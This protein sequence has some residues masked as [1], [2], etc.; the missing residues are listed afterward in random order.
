[1][2]AEFNLLETRIA[3]IKCY[4]TALQKGV[5]ED[6]AINF[7]TNL[8]AMR[9]PYLTLLEIDRYIT[10]WIEE[11][12]PNLPC[13]TTSIVS[14]STCSSMNKNCFRPSMKKDQS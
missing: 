2:A 11:V 7:A 9:H 4:V 10:S 13:E 12:I 1:M 3:V 5:E 14:C 8:F 6:R